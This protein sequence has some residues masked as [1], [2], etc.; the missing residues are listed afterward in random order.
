MPVNNE[1]ILSPIIKSIRS[2]AFFRKLTK[3]NIGQYKLDRNEKEFSSFTVDLLDGRGKVQYTGNFIVTTDRFVFREEQGKKPLVIELPFDEVI[4][5]KT[6]KKIKFSVDVY[7]N[8]NIFTFKFS[9]G[10]VFKE[11]ISFVTKKDLVDVITK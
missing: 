7:I 1:S 3:Y 10:G 6:N 9:D 8:E 2:G 4:K 11:F 5:L